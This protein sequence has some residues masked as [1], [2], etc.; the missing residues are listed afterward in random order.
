V[1]LDDRKR[2]LELLA[3]PRGRSASRAYDDTRMVS[4]ERRGKWVLKLRSGQPRQWKVDASLAALRRPFRPRC[5]EVDGKRLSGKRW[6]Y[7]ERKR[8]LRMELRAK[9]ARIAT[10]RRC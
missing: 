5:I 9:R 2:M 6:S 4:R 7:S 3:F 1:S 10:L 8:V